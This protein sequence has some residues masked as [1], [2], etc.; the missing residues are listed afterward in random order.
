MAR[1]TGHLFA[2]SME[3]RRFEAAAPAFDAVMIRWQRSVPPGLILSS[4][5]LRAIVSP[6]TGVD[7]IG[8]DAA[9]HRGV[10]VFSL[11]HHPPLLRNVTSTAE[12]AFGLLLSLVRRIPQA[13]SSVK[14]AE[15]RQ[16]PFF[17]RELSGLG[18]G[19]LG[20]GRLGRMMARYGRAF[21]MRV[22][23]YDPHPGSV[24]GY[25][26]R[27]RS[28]RSL[29]ARSDVLT[30]HLPLNARTAGAVGEAEFR[31]LP[32]G[33]VLINTS[34]G[35][36][37]DEQALLR[38]LRSGHLAGAALDVLIGERKGISANHPLVQYARS[39][40]NLLVTPHLGG[41]TAEAMERTDLFVIGEFR[42]WAE[43]GS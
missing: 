42:Q 7:H 11:H 17:G 36:I 26:R 5:R 39:H 8:V 43:R 20:F 3:Q 15:W 16:S 37:V 41:A 4:P 22:A 24:P 40:P 25:V 9:A 1:R 27:A 32:K 18:L 14:R 29:L 23:A 33:S 35:E 21:G 19:I 34:R 31:Q 6:T 2:E 28:L 30:L 38:S 13:C 10:R 12:H